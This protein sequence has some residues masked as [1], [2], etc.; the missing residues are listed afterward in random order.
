[1]ITP[2]FTIT[3]DEEYIYVQIKVSSVRFSTSGIELV[4]DGCMFIF[5]LSPYYLRLR[6][7]DELVE[8]EE[9]NKVEYDSKQESINCKIL[10]AVKGKEFQDLDLPSKMLA[11]KNEPK[12]A[13][14]PLIQEVSTEKESINDIREEGE[15]FDWE[16]KQEI[17]V[18][19]TPL[20]KYGFDNMYTGFIGVSIANGNDINELDDPEHT[21]AEERVKER[22][23]KENLK[24]DPEYYAAEYMTTKH[25]DEEDVQINGIKRLLEYVPPLYESYQQWYE[26]LDVESKEKYPSFPVEFTEKEQNQM[27]DHIPKKNYLVNDAKSQYLTLLSILYSYTFEQIENEGLHTTESQWTIG[28]LTPQ[29]AMLDQQI[30]LSESM[31]HFSQIKGIIITA[32]RR[33]LSYPLHRNYNL[34]IRAWQ[35]TIGLLLGGKRLVIKALLDIHELFRYHDVYYVYTK[36]L[37]DDLCAWLIS[38]GNE[39]VI[40][41]LALQARKELESIEKSDTEFECI[42][43][44]DEETGEVE[45]E[46]L[47]IAEIEF[48]S[49]QEMSSQSTLM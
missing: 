1:M 21:S 47:T 37:L 49:E 33:T 19:D 8:D 23:K 25:G 13:E 34:C 39:N 46:T 29:I 35:F 32:I 10:K 5:H 40:K 38:Q 15:Q 36:I 27:Q 41:S 28:K 4:I 48:L 7:S 2:R 42:S 43:G 14:G 11:A 3:Q 20:C 17:H 24:F 22:L 44:V 45:W 26:K 30:L 16:V 18:D 9:L 31:G 6:L 12:K